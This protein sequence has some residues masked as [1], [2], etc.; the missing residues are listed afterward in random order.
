MGVSVYAVLGPEYGPE[1]EGLVAIVV[2]AFYGLKTSCARWAEHLADTLRSLGW[3]RS[4]AL[5][6]V[7]M[8]DCGT[9][10]EYLAVYSDDIIVASKDPKSVYDIIQKMSELNPI[11]G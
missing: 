5:S 11:P 9:H 4:K 10:Y 6:D 3:E 1:L 7:W 8:K 2:K